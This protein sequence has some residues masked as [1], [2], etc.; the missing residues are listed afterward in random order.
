M[1]DDLVKRL[2]EL[3]SWGSLAAGQAADRIEKLEEAVDI[4]QA[5]IVAKKPI[6]PR[7]K[8]AITEAREALEKKND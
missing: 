1:T 7:F 5:V 3:Q 8:K 4:L 6:P 2:R